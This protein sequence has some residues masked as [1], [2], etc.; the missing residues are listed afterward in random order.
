MTDYSDHFTVEELQCPMTMKLELQEGFIE[1]LEDLRAHYN[2]PMI[3]TSGCRVLEYNEIL[4]HEGFR[5]SVNSFHIID[6]KKY[7]TDCCAVDIAKPNIYDQAQLI[8]YALNLGWTVR[9]G[10]SFIHLDLRSLY[11]NLKQHFDFYKK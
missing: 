9:I 3:V 6:N 4:I 10:N 7:E 2:K 8:R 1:R 11:T 5:A